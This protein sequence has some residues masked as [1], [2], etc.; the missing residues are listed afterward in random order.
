MK[1]KKETQYNKEDDDVLQCL[2]PYN[3]CEL[4]QTRC[5]PSVGCPFFPGRGRALAK[6]QVGLRSF[7]ANKSERVARYIP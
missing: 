3:I 5:V 1:N 2:P 6:S 4:I 7:Q